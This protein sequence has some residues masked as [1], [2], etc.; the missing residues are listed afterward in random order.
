[1]SVLIYI[2][3]WC[4]M[5]DKGV[6]YMLHWQQRCCLC[7]GCCYCGCGCCGNVSISVSIV[8]ADCWRR[9]RQKLLF[10]GTILLLF[11]LDECINDAELKSVHE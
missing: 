4:T 5:V 3:L 11:E 6:D 8:L 2:Q 9:Q 7:E 1:M 10:S